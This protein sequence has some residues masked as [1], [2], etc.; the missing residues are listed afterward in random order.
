MV[1]TTLKNTPVGQPQEIHSRLVNWSEE[2]GNGYKSM[3]SFYSGDDTS[4]IY[5]VA[6]LNIKEHLI[7]LV[8]A[9][10]YDDESANLEELVDHGW[11]I[12]FTGPVIGG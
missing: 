9:R 4:G 6:L 7:F 1:N 2:E 10:G 5:P 12:I 3:A 11:K 8:R